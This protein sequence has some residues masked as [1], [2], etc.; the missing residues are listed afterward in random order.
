MPTPYHT[1]DSA[2]IYCADN[3][4]VDW[5]AADLV[6]TDPPYSA[7]TH[8]GARTSADWDVSGG[9]QAPALGIGFAPMTDADVDA[10][11]ARIATIAQR[12]VVSFLDWRHTARLDV[13]PPEGLRFVRAGIW[14]KPN[15]A[16]QFTGDRPGTGWE[17]IAILHTAGGR[18]RWNG[19]GAHAVWTHPVAHA[20]HRISDHPNAK[21][22]PL[23]IELIKLFSNPGDLVFDPFGGSGAVAAAA[24]LTRR[25]CVIIE[26]DE[27]YCADLAYYLAHHRPYRDGQGG[28]LP[29]FE[30]V[31]E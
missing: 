18:M 4:A 31:G 2:T 10:T 9:N 19:G 5:P 14:V 27:R 26:Q 13:C 7:T 11:F 16:P 1:T 8:N 6:L 30:G 29:L 24:H 20:A 25:R 28:V 15:G 12:W 3:R 23:L 21:P 17:S 22:I